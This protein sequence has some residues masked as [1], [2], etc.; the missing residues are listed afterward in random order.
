MHLSGERGTG[1][2]RVFEALLFLAAGWGQPDSIVTVA[3]TR[4]AAALVNGETVHSKLQ[5]FHN[6][7]PTMLQLEEWSKVHML[8]WDE[9][10]M[11]G[12][13]LFVKPIKENKGISGYRRRG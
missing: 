11:T 1:K 10:S 3:L 9:I 6:R 7:K 8:I 4:I 13:S 5:I 2:S 12:H